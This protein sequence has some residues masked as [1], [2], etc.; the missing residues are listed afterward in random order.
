MYLTLKRFF[1]KVEALRSTIMA[2]MWQS[3]K[4]LC[5]KHSR[6]NSAG[7]IVK[8]K[9]IFHLSSVRKQIV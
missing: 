8:Y 9:H 1:Y 7:G 5:A 6:E 3:R 4:Q 2:A